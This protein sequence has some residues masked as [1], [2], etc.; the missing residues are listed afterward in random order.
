MKLSASAQ[1][2]GDT[3]DAEER[4]ARAATIFQLALDY[5]RERDPNDKDMITGSLREQRL[6]ALLTSRAY[7]DASRFAS[8]SIAANPAH[9]ETMG[10]PLKRE[11]DRLQT[12]GRFDDALRLIESVK[13]MNPKLADQFLGPIERY[14]QEIRQRRD[15]AQSAG[16]GGSIVP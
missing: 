13:G 9:Q 1:E 3:Q 10:V 6:A 11:V 14:E 7:N 5:F 15:A 2:A 8:E 12:S 4:A 16:E